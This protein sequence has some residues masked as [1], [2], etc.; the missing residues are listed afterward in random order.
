[1]EDMTADEIRQFLDEA[2]RRKERTRDSDAAVVT[3]EGVTQPC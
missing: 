1:M 2:R 3:A